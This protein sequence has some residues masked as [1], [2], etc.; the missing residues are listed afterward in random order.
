[1]DTV[2]GLAAQ[3]RGSGRVKGTPQRYSAQQRGSQRGYRQDAASHAAR[4]I[5]DTGEAGRPV[6]AWRPWIHGESTSSM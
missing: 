3:E 5:Q 2:L 6:R 4:S 1:M